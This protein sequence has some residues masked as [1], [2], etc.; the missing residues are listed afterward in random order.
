[1]LFPCISIIDHL[2]NVRSNTNTALPGGMALQ[3][4]SLTQEA[5]IYLSIRGLLQGPQTSRR[6]LHW[7]MKEC[8]I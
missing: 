8:F 5:V 3:T 2:F 4:K 1:M 7:H 6:S